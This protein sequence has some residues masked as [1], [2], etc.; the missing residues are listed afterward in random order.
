MKKWKAN[1]SFDEDDIFTWFIRRR[2]SGVISCGSN[3]KFN[4]EE[5]MKTAIQVV[6]VDCT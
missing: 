4:K 1:N 2:S 6:K 5:T 3:K